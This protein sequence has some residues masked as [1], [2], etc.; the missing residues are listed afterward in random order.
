MGG[1]TSATKDAWPPLA[2]QSA[3]HLD[4]VK[5]PRARVHPTF[6][7]LEFFP[8]ISATQ[9]QLLGAQPV[10]R[11]TFPAPPKTLQL[12]PCAPFHDTGLH[13]PFPITPSR[14]ARLAL[15][16]GLPAITRGK[17]SAGTGTQYVH[18]IW[19][20]PPPAIARKDLQFCTRIHGLSGPSEPSHYVSPCRLMER[21]AHTGSKCS[22]DSP[23]ANHLQAWRPTPPSQNSTIRVASCSWHLNLAYR[24]NSNREDAMALDAHDPLKHTR[25]EFLVPTKAQLKV[26][27]L[28]E[29]GQKPVTLQ[30]PKPLFT[31][32]YFTTWATQGVHGHFKPLAGS[33]LPTWLDADT[34]ASECIAPIVG[35]LS[36]EVAVME[37]LTANLHLLL[38]A[39]YRPDING[40]HKII[41]ESQAFP[42]DHFAAES[43]ILHH[44][45]SSETSLVTIEAPALPQPPL[46]TSHILSVI[47]EHSSTTAL[48]LLPGI[49]FYTGQLLDIPTITAVAQAAGIFVIWDLAHA[50]GNVPLALHDWNVD[51]AAWCSYKYL[52]AGPGAAGGLFVHERNGQVSTKGGKKVFVNR[53]SGWWGSD[54]SSRFAMDNKFVPIQGAAGFQLSN[55]SILD[56]TSLT[57]SLEVFALAGGIGPLREKSVKLTAYLEILLLGMKTHGEKRFDILTPKEPEAR[58]AQLS[59]KLHPGLLD[60]VML[61]L[62]ERGVVVDERRPDVIR[63]APAPLYNTFTDCWDFVEAFKEALLVAVKR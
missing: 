22:S 40:R 46:S 51:A 6:A 10:D 7:L 3:P 56:I 8:L 21:H 16:P 13:F 26:K 62:E 59:L 53:L 61:A 28:P 17:T 39:F 24:Y 41:I 42:S 5:L 55:P 57:A 43:Q 33:P 29:A 15:E 19:E 20:S 52:N 14:G 34:K 48:L 58:G 36:S 23:V 1:C 63:V 50:V 4:R 47:K 27:S 45:L 31:Y 12:A 30:G 49:Q 60:K 11:K 32:V 44:N 38:S 37:T 9:R 2:P 18:W 25:R 54:K 35:A